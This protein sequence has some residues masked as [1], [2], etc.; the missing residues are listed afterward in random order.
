MVVVALHRISGALVALALLP[1]AAMAQLPTAQGSQL[2][3][4]SGWIF[5]F[6]PYGWLPRVNANL[7]YN[8]P[9]A[10]SITCGVPWIRMVSYSIFSF[11]QSAM[12]ALP[13]PSFRRC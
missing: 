2:A 3:A 10:F 7:S 8:L 13:S 5:N 9:P 4:P 1:S 11:R 12:H 6:A